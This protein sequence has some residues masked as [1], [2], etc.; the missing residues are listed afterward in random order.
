M[1]QQIIARIEAILG[2][3]DAAS[4]G[5]MRELCLEV[6]EHIEKRGDDGIKQTMQRVR[7]ALERVQ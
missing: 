2:K 6:V 4:S 1:K 7:A 5:V 3:L